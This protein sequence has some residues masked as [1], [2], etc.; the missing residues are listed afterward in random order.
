[1]KTIKEALSEV[2]LFA[3]LRFNRVL[4]EKIRE[5]VNVLSKEV[6]D[7][8]NKLPQNIT[9]NVPETTIPP[10]VVPEIKV[11][12]INVTVPEI[13]VPDIILPTINVPPI[14]LPKFVLPEIKIPKFEL[15]SLESVSK[16]VKELLE[17]V[18]TLK[19]PRL[20]TDPVSVRL[21]DGDKFIDSLT[22]VVSQ[23]GIG[24]SGSGEVTPTSLN[25]GVSTVTSA[26]TRVQLSG[27]SCVSVTVKAHSGN[28]GTIYVGGSNVTSANGLRL[29]AGESV[30]L[31]IDHPGKVYVDGSANGDGVSYLF[32]SR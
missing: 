15:P 32:N 3:N 19:L 1:M 30:A 13:K 28:S 25:S 14:K 20:A 4:S 16:G 31:S 2:K 12:P 26:G 23:G 21:S 29:S 8:K 7:I 27:Q 17:Y 5:D 10:V 11:P 9:I 22:T 6:T 24:G 18:K